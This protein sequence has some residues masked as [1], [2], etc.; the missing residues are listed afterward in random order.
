[1]RP[2]SFQWKDENTD[3]SS[4]HLDFVAQEVAQVLPEIVADHKWREIPDTT[5]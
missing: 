4:T 2:I 1:M 5:E 3:K